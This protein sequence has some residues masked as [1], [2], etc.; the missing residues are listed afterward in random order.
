MNPGRE[1]DALVAE[2]VMGWGHSRYFKTE[3]SSAVAA[4]KR[5][6]GWNIWKDGKWAFLPHFSTDIA[7]AWEVAEKVGCVI[8]RGSFGWIVKDDWT[9]A[10]GIETD[11]A[12]HAIC[13]FAL[14]VMG[15]LKVLPESY[16]TL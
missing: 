2:K 10:D 6:D 13:L 9:D 4:L 7:A 1:L 5:L 3:D 12:P 16:E 15:T 14:K 8:G 11:S